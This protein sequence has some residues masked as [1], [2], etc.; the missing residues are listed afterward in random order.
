VLIPYPLHASTLFLA[1]V[2]YTLKHQSHIL[3]EHGSLVRKLYPIGYLSQGEIVK[4][5]TYSYKHILIYIPTR[6]YFTIRP[7]D[8]YPIG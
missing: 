3:I 4:Y 6:I 1:Q 5:I 2:V 8:R 7:Y